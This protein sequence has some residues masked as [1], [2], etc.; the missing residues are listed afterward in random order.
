MSVV[1]V[2]PSPSEQK[3][4]LK[5]LLDSGSELISDADDGASFFVISLQWYNA[6]RAHIDLNDSGRD[7]E[8][9]PGP[10]NN[11]NLLKNAN[12]VSYDCMNLI[13]FFFL[14]CVYLQDL[15]H[16][17]FLRL[18]LDCVSTRRATSDSQALSSGRTVKSFPKHSGSC[19]WN[20][21]RWRRDPLSWNVQS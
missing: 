13:F 19:C 4:K 21:I 11:T 12:E 1:P 18:Q 6:F 3:Q 9:H 17:D 14:D 16:D 8:P 15:E 7:G 2:A 20:G 10:I 5:E